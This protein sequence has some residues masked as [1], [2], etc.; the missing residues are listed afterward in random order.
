M[1]TAMTMPRSDCLLYSAAVYGGFDEAPSAVASCRAGRDVL[2]YGGPDATAVYPSA[3]RPPA[4]DLYDA[5]GP[6]AVASS[7]F[8]GRLSAGAKPAFPGP[9]GSYSSAGDCYAE[10]PTSYQVVTTADC[11]MAD[12][13]RRRLQQRRSSTFSDVVARACRMLQPETTPHQE[14]QQ[15]Q[16]HQLVRPTTYKWMTVKRGPP[17]T[18]G[19]SSADS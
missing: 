1:N 18:T 16:P 19:E 5:R 10:F 13:D 7:P 15:Q 3:E 12:E 6:R 17:K 2:D 9:A 11:A 4:A 14:Q 8:F